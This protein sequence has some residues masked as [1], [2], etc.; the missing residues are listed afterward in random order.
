MMKINSQCRDCGSPDLYKFLDLGNQPLANSFLKSDDL[1]KQEPRYPLEGY[2][3]RSCNL[4]QLLHVVDKGELFRDYVYFSSGMP[5]VSPHWKSYA[6]E[7]IGNFLHPRD[8]VVEVGSN[9]GI[10]LRF[11]KD[12]KFRIL[13]VDPAENI[14]RVATE[15]GIPTIADFFSEATA[16]D[17]FQKYGPAKAIM[18]NNVFAHIDDHHD[19]CKGVGALLDERGVLVIEAPYLIDMFENLAYDTIYHE[20][21]S[22]LSVLPLTKLFQKHNLEIFDVKIVSA[23]GQSLRLFVGRQGEHSVGRAVHDFIKKELEMGLHQERSYDALANRIEHSKNQLQKLLNGLKK[24]NKK[25]A[26]YGAPAKGNTLLNYCKIGSDGLDYALEDLPS[27]QGFYTPGM[28]IP[29]VTRDFAAKNQPDY[30]LLLAWNYMRP[31]LDKEQEFIKKGGRFIMPIGD[32]IKIIGD[33]RN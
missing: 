26:A 29:V 19:F 8:L 23:Q 20:H 3:C 17:I 11:F 15:A 1:K 10:L 33:T 21:L 6:E 9:D 2:F 31:I 5:K 24:Q 32:D 28:H 27:K 7:I 4:A 12:F 16:K 30:Y 22:Y 25:I 13:G 18:A 14:A